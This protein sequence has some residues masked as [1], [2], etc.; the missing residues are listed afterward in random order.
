MYSQITTFKNEKFLLTDDSQNM[1][2][3][4]AMRSVEVGGRSKTPFSW[5]NTKSV[6]SFI[7]D[8]DFENRFKPFGYKIGIILVCP[9][10]TTMTAYLYDSEKI[11]VAI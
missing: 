4:L 6:Q 7:N 1:P 3:G 9:D 2:I 10:D 11:K 8:I 5:E